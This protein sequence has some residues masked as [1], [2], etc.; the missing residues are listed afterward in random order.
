MVRIRR[1]ADLTPLVALALLS[2]PAGAAPQE[3]PAAPGPSRE[4]LGR[5]LAETERRLAEA[6]AELEASRA[7]EA[8]LRRQ[9]AAALPAAA[10]EGRAVRVREPLTYIP[11]EQPATAPE[12]PLAAAGPPAAVPGF[13]VDRS[14]TCLRLRRAASLTATIVDCLAPGTRMK[15]LQESGDWGEV[16]LADGRRG[17]LARRYLELESPVDRGEAVAEAAAS[18][19]RPAAPAATAAA[20]GEP[21]PEAAV[22]ALQAW[23]DAW[24]GQRVDDYLALYSRGFRPP[25]EMS[26]LEW[27]QRRRRRLSA[28]QYIRLE[29]SSVRALPADDGTVRV[30]FRQRYESDTFQDEVTKVLVWVAEDGGWRILSEESTP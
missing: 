18:S 19:G 10:T 15:L 29:L 21:S 8:E 1:L 11:E 4:E 14:I 3:D 20:G 24:S 28:P 5:R 30:S 2:A 16:L 26:R 22:E 13:Q 12:S 6:L 23:A 25:P 7:R 17:W 27:E 9:L